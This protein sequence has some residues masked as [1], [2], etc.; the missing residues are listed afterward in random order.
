MSATFICPGCNEENAYFNGR[1]YDCPDCG[2][3]WDE[4]QS[5]DSSYNYEQEEFERLIKLKEPYFTL[6]HGKLYE[7]DVEYASG[8]FEE[9]TII[10]LAFQDGRNKQFILGDARRFLKQYP[11][12]VQEIINMDYS[13]LWN[14]GLSDYPSDFETMASVF[15]T[16]RDGTGLDGSGMYYY[17][18]KKTDEL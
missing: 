9:T 15:T 7:C 12:I 2:M 4:N 17:E 16:Q 5:N 13:T 6:E 18:F 3:E 1:F 10:P 11:Q 14:D 8:K